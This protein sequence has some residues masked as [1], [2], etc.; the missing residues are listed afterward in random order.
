M[1]RDTKKHRIFDAVYGYIELNDV[2]FKLVNSPLF[3]R[4]HW[5]KQLGPLYTIFPSAQHS[6]FS[7]SIGVFHIMKKMIDRLKDEIPRFETGDDG[8]KCLRLAALLHDIG[9]VPLSHIGENA[10]ISSYK[11]SQQTD[12]VKL[13][14]RTGWR[15]LF[16]EE[17]RATSTKLHELISAYIILNSKEIEDIL[18]EIPGWGDSENPGRREG[19]IK[20]I[21]KII[22]G[23]HQNNIFSSMLHSELDA[24]RLD[25]LLRDSFFTGVDYGKIDLD[26]IVSRFSVKKDRDQ[27][28]L[29]LGH[30]GIHTL[31]HYVLGRYFLNVQVIFNKKVRLMDILYKIIIDYLVVEAKEGFSDCGMMDLKEL[32]NCIKHRTESTRDRSHLHQF[33]EYTDALAFTKIRLLHD[34]LDEKEKSSTA[35]EKELFINDCIKHIMDGSI[36][37]PAVSH[38]RLVIINNF[39]DKKF[40]DVLKKEA[41]K[42]VV[43]ISDDHSIQKERIIVN[44]ISESSMKYTRLEEEVENLREAIR[45]TYRDRAGNDIVKYLA[46]SNASILSRL[47]DNNLLIL[48]VY[49]LPSKKETK[50]KIKQ[51]EDIVK[52][53][54]SDF[55]DS[56]F[57]RK[58]SRCGCDKDGHLCQITPGNENFKEIWK[59]SNNPKY[60]CEKCGRVANAADFLCRPV[61][62]SD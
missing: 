59:L 46:E 36:P 38:Q 57:F 31:E 22:T 14:V 6:R 19:N 43:K 53:A 10:L 11:P 18:K 15:S 51:K 48:N 4:L 25:Y 32:L 13:D 62:F 9:H 52:N 54:F 49:Y 60:L 5:I 12:S 7:H 35:T 21:A 27:Y 33:Y 28:H 17:Y 56:H 2:E 50:E 55:I 47:I 61:E 39:E 3:Q 24:D 58:N 8:E 42:I 44:I 16:D 1:P 37:S 29:C 20:N 45:I 26:Y 34:H 30:K 41:E 40:A 23:Q